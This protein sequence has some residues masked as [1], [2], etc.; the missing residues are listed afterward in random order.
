MRNDKSKYYGYEI[1][2]KE[3]LL[4]DYIY[5]NIFTFT[6]E[7]LDN[8][9]N[10]LN[11]IPGFKIEIDFR[12]IAL[13]KL[14]MG[15][16]NKKW[17]DFILSLVEDCGNTHL[18]RIFRK[19]DIEK[20]VPENALKTGTYSTKETILAKLPALLVELYDTF[21]QLTLKHAESLTCKDTF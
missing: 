5:E 7:G 8:L 9:K 17:V 21:E 1:Q 15:E 19:Y 4:I 11:T 12:E 16:E 13:R 6:N 14:R 18:D 3:E 10:K 20:M 2:K